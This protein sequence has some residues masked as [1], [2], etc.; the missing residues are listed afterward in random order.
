MKSNMLGIVCTFPKNLAMT[1]L[2]ELEGVGRGTEV[3][4][5]T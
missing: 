3:E 4:W 1:K 5:T 2:G